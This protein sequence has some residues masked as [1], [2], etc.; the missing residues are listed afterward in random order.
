MSFTPGPW[1][2]ETKYACLGVFDSKG[3]GVADIV[4]GRPDDELNANARLIAAAP[5][6]YGLLADFA[7][8][9][10]SDGL[11]CAARDLL[12]RIERGE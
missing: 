1:E 4:Y 7:N 6:M 9:E 10:H 3:S 2:V 8:G 12:R 5:E 11:F